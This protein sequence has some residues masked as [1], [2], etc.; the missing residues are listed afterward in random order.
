MFEDE[1]SFQQ[2]G[3]RTTTWAVKGIGTIVPQF[4][5]R[6]S[7]KVFGAVTA[8]VNPR[9]HFRFAEVFNAQ[10]F[11]AFLEQ[12]ITRYAPQKIHLVLDNVRYHYA[13][14]NQ[15][16]LRKMRKRLELHFLPAYS[17]NLNATEKVWKETRQRGT[18]NRYFE[19]IDTLHDALFTQ[20]N[21]F[22]GNPASLRNV[23]AP[24]AA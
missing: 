19:V 6:K 20:F 11:K 10:T 12:L 16:W 22:Q 2:H 18:H 7:L 4:P 8:E 14:C 1:A 13:S 21:R 23:I 24:F 9:F 5:T 15:E 3:T 17:P